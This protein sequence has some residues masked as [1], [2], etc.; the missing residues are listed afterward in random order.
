MADFALHIS[1]WNLADR[2]VQY[3]AIKAFVPAICD[4][5]MQLIQERGTDIKANR[6][7]SGGAV[8]DNVR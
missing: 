7:E 4:K 8:D 2:A 1:Y 5:R 3:N 6:F